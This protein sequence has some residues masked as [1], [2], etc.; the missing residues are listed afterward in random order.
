MYLFAPKHGIPHEYLLGVMQSEPFADL[1]RISNQGDARVIPQVKAAKLEEMPIPKWDHNDRT[2]I[3]IVQSVGALLKLAATDSP[4][5][6]RTF[7]AQRRRLDDLVAALY[8]INREM[9]S[10]DAS[11]DSLLVAQG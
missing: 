7:S 6:Q 10:S 9:P 11:D 3:A 4:G 5:S 1:Y 2:Q 8:G